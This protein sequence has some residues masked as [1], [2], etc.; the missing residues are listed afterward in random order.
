MKSLKE[1][2]LANIEDTLASGDTAI[3]KIKL[4]ARERIIKIISKA[5]KLNDKNSNILRNIINDSTVNDKYKYISCFI[6][7]KLRTTLIKISGNKLDK[8]DFKGFPT[9][10]KEY[11]F[12][13]T[14]DYHHFESIYNNEN[15]EIKDII[16]QAKSTN[17]PI[18]INYGGLK[19]SCIKLDDILVLTYRNLIYI[20]I[21]DKNS[22]IHRLVIRM[23]NTYSPGFT[24]FLDLI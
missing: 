18:E 16:E 19:V 14:W 13:C 8:Q 5:G 6:P 20:M 7:S 4:T 15:Q 12:R 9:D 1:S 17:K 2:L 23:N 24:Q 3:E 22:V 11:N 10:T 21:T